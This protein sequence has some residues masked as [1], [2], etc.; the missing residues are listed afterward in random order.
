MLHTC[1]CFASTAPCRRLTF[2]I[3]HGHVMKIQ[4]YA[5]VWQCLG[6]VRCPICVVFGGGGAAFMTRRGE[7][8]NY[9]VGISSRMAGHFRK[10]EF[11]SMEGLGHFACFESPGRFGEL[12]QQ[13]L[14]R[15]E[16]DMDH[17]MQQQLQPAG[18]RSK[19]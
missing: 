14:P 13:V 15:F 10:G 4:S 18:S 11:R 5:T 7:P 9:R 8:Q 1:A 17:Q 3:L 12:L 19:L 6:D 16:G 2:S